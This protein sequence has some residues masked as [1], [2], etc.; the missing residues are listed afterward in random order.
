[1]N[2]YGIN[3]AVQGFQGGMNFANNQQRQR[4]VLQREA[5][6]RARDET[7]S[8]VE[9]ER[10]AMGSQPQPQQAIQVPQVQGQPQA[11]QAPTVGDA[12]PSAAP[13]PTVGDGQPP[14]PGQRPPSPQPGSAPQP[15][16]GEQQGA[17][18]DAFEGAMT[19]A[20]NLWSAPAA[21]GG[22]GTNPDTARAVVT[23]EGLTPGAVIVQGARQASG[24]AAG[25]L[26]RGDMNAYFDRARQLFAQRGI[27]HLYDEWQG[28]AMQSLQSS[29]QRSL[30]F[31]AVAAQGGNMQ[32]AAQWVQRAYGY[33]P[34]GMNAQVQVGPDGQLTAQRVG[35]DGQPVGQPH[36]LGAQ[37]LREMA[38]TMADPGA[39]ETLLLNREGMAIRRDTLNETIRHNQAAEGIARSRAAAGGRGG[40]GRGPTPPS[41]GDQRTAQTVVEGYVDDAMEEFRP[42]GNGRTVNRNAVQAAASQLVLTGATDP[43]TAT[44]FAAAQAAGNPNIQ[45][46]WQRT[47]SGYLPIGALPGG[48]PIV[49][50]GPAAQIAT[51]VLG[52]PPQA[53]PTTGA[54]PGTRRNQ[55]P[56]AAIQR[57]A[58]AAVDP[59]ART[60]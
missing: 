2:W 36:V 22:Q 52:G 55:T 35:A 10:A 45:Y 34:D 53:A 24:N 30:A 3:A 8:Q 28:R 19:A 51:A 31:A 5:D 57:P 60:E 25:P 58:P 20:R 18:P 49:L 23:G 41:V 12:G 6:E 27:G 56:P 15:S 14:I 7:I 4:T 44:R 54:V 13:A 47:E 9:R 37:Q 39:M 59:R 26:G 43:H 46:R 29:A 17:Q 16:T 21:T 48:Q 42:R 1:M 11:P 32:A 40:A 50:T 38:L 33:I